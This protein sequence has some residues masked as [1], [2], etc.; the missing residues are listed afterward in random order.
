MI[1]GKDGCKYNSEKWSTA[2]VSEHIPSWNSMSTIWTFDGKENKHDV[3]RNEDCM[4][5]F[6]GSLREHE[7]KIINFGKKKMIPLTN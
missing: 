5:K 4:K 7:L 2:K 1:K 6:C 3:Y